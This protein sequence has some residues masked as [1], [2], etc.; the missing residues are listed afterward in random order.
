MRLIEFTKKYGDEAACKQLFKENREKHGLVCRKCS[1]S[2]FHWLKTANRWQCKSC[3][4]QIGLRSGTLLQASN[5]PYHY[6]I[7]AIYLMTN[8][9]KGISALEMQRQLGHKRYEPIWAMMHKIRAAM[10]NRDDRYTM[11]GLTELDDGFIKANRN[12]GKKSTKR[13]RGTE[14]K[15]SVLMMAS[16]SEGKPDG[17]K[18]TA[19]RYIT[20]K[21]MKDQTSKTINQTIQSK[22]NPAATEVISDNFRGFSKV[23]Q[24]IDKHHSMNVPKDFASTALPWVHTMIS[25]AKRTLLGINHSVSETYLQNYLN[26]FC[27]KVNR[28]YFNEN[29]F[30]RL[31]V[32]AVSEPW[33]GTKDYNYG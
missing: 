31:M 33:F 3:G 22:T 30:D 1:N 20:M 25:N 8:T 15:T 12:D 21:V 4:A 13:G 24:I 17:A 23:K 2:S 7:Y 16:V 27:Y 14:Q 26:E 6:W 5:L 29:L 18:P 10:G 9:K 11:E 28:R 19:L 32:A